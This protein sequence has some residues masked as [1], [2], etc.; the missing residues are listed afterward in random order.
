MKAED[1]VFAYER[2]DLADGRTV[3]LKS[4]Y[5]TMNNLF[6]ETINP[7]VGDSTSLRKYA[8][9]LLGWLHVVMLSLLA[10]LFGLS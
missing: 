10:G 3:G 2:R 7:K 4:F 1:I 8:K 6:R 9:N 5:Y